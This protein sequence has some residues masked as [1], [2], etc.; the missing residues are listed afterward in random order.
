MQK[1]VVG[2]LVVR[3]NFLVNCPQRSGAISEGEKYTEAYVGHQ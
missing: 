3:V 1:E 2:G